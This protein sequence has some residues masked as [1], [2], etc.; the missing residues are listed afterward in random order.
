MWTSMQLVDYEDY[1]DPIAIYSLLALSAIRCRSFDIASKAF[2]KLEEM[3]SK[4]E[5]E[6]YEQLAESIFIRCEIF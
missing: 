3:S 2:V 4:D 1:L 5:K 6:E